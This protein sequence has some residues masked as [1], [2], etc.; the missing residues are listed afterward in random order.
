MLWWIPAMMKSSIVF[1]RNKYRFSSKVNLYNQHKVQTPHWK[2]VNVNCSEVSV[3]RQSISSATATSYMQKISHHKVQWR[4]GTNLPCRKLDL[5]NGIV[6]CLSRSADI[7]ST[8][9]FPPWNESLR[10]QDESPRMS[11]DAVRL[12]SKKEHSFAY[13]KPRQFT[14]QSHRRR[15][16]SWEEPVCKV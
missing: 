3:H 2:R 14:T 11:S 15:I 5:R 16:S 10:W 12:K 4:E 7:E 1:W 9:P 13:I 8:K 6:D